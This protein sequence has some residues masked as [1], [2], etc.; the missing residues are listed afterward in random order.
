MQQICPGWPVYVHFSGSADATLKEAFVYVD[1]W[2][3]QVYPSL[4]RASHVV[5]IQGANQ[6]HCQNRIHREKPEE[7]VSY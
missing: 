6:Q 5:S 4:T 7:A 3:V 2:S 1:P